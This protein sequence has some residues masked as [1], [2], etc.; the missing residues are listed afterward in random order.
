MLADE[1]FTPDSSRYWD[2]ESHSPGGPQA[3]FDKQ[4]IRDWLNEQDWDKT[5]PAPELPTEVI[6]KS[7]EKYLEA[8]RR[9]TGS[10]LV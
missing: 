4:Y 10:P 6:E 1:I 2:S 7:V 5:P 8:Y 9:I 3:S